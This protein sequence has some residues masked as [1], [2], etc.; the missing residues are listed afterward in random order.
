MK[1]ISEPSVVNKKKHERVI[2]QKNKKV[3]KA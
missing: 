2:V 1:V 3:I